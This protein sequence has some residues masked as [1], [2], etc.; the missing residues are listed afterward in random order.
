MENNSEKNILKVTVFL[1]LATADDLKVDQKTPKLG[2][3]FWVRSCN[4]GQFDNQAYIIDEDTDPYEI[5][6]WLEQDMIYIPVSSIDAPTLK[7]EQYD[8]QQV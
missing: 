5:A 7:A 1:K 6:N 3:P 2:Q 4:S 8:V